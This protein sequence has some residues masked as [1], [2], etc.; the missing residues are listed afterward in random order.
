VLA[1]SNR[2]DKYAPNTIFKRDVFVVIIELMKITTAAH[3][4]P[5]RP[6]SPK[7]VRARVQISKLA[8]RSFNKH[9]LLVLQVLWFGT[10]LIGKYFSPIN[11]R[12]AAF[13]W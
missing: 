12:L 6:N 10:P 8:P 13:T 1:E 9:C 3:T 2:P 5:G 7:L 11:G 4:V